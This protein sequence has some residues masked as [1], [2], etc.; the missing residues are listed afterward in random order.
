MDELASTFPEY[1]VVMGMDD[2]GHA[3]GPQ[4]IAEIGDVIRFHNK[5]AL[6]TFAELDPGAN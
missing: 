2:V 4:L 5:K 1:T 3:L 6:I